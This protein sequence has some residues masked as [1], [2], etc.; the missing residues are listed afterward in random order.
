M[1]S[2]LVYIGA[3]ILLAAVPVHYAALVVLRILQAFGSA[4]VVSMGAGTVA[5]VSVLHKWSEDDRFAD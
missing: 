3:N 2:L 5:D 1:I 4:A